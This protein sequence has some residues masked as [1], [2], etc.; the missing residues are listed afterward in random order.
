MNAITSRARFVAIAKTLRAFALKTLALA[1]VVSCFSSAALADTFT[2]TPGSGTLP[3]IPAGPADLLWDTPGL[4][5][6]GVPFG[7]GGMG[8]VAGD[9]VDAI[10]DGFDDVLMPHSV[11]FSVTIGSFGAPG[12]GVSAEV[13]GDTPPGFTPGH[14]S[15]L[16][17]SSPALVGTNI[18]APAPFGWTP[19]T[20][21]GDEANAGLSNL[22]VAPDEVNA[23]DLATIGPISATPVF[24]SLV[25]GSPTLGGLGASGADILVVGGPF[26]LV[27]TVFLPAAALG[28]PATIGVVF[29]MDALAL[30]LLPGYVFGGP[31]SIE[32]SLDSGSAASVGFSGADILG[33]A[34]G[35][36][37]PVL[38][39]SF[40]SL[41][42]LGTDEIDALDVDR[43][44]IV[45]EPGGI[46]MFTLGGI[47]MIG[48]AWRR[49]RQR[50]A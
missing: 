34:A 15:D 3:A 50:R 11:Y 13:L 10:S 7:A 28:L 12:S 47:A 14:A 37:A 1:V 9:V 35:P 18:L 29:E 23:Y 22:A 8:L 36:P 44:I 21:T 27:P 16:F 41:G 20:M 48:C 24:F 45:P 40:L 38:A 49:R 5:S 26:G 46:I 43:Q 19:G 17:V 32:Y 2:L 30:E 39:H 6:V 4:P 33:L 42:L 25:A 31:G